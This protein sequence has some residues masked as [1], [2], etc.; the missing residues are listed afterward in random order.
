VIKRRNGTMRVSFRYLS[1]EDVIECGGL[2]MIETLK[3]VETATL[4][5]YSGNAI[6]A[7]TANLFW[8]LPKDKLKLSIGYPGSKRINIHAAYLNTNPKIVGIKN[9]PSNPENPIKGRGPRASGLITLVND[10]TGYPYALMDAAIISGTRTGALAGLGAK[11]LC[12]NK[13]ATV[14]LVGLGPINRSAFTAVKNSIPQT[15]KAKVFDISKERSEKFK[16][17][18]QAQFDI[19]VVIASSAKDAIYESDIVMPATNVK[20]PEDAYIE[21]SWLK[22]GCLFIDLSLWDAKFDIFKKA[23]KLVVNSSL[24]LDRKNITPGCLVHQGD[25]KSDNFIDIGSVIHKEMVGR[26]NESEI[27]VYF[28]RGMAIYDVINAYR[29]YKSAEEKGIGKLLNLWENPYWY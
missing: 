17:E 18:I 6:E 13:P 21:Y 19:E 22:P 11:Y 1:Q 23:N 14:G 4:L 8:D 10:E 9:I 28:A 12:I 29:V 27:I 26:Q 15:A 24:S 25:F 5:A 20:S 2:N 3:D 7:T 16:K